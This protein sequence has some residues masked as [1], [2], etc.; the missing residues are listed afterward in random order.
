MKAVAGAARR[1]SGSHPLQYALA[2]RADRL[3]RAARQGRQDDHRAREHAAVAD[4]GRH[5]VVERAALQAAAEDRAAEQDVLQDRQTRFRRS[6]T[7][8]SRMPRTRTGICTCTSRSRTCSRWATSFR[9][10]VGR[11]LT[12]RPAAGSA[13][14]SAVFSAC[15]RWPIEDTRIVPGPRAGARSGR[16]QGSG[17]HVHHD[18]RSSDDAV[19]QR[20]GPDR[21]RCGPPDQGIRCADGQSRRVRAPRLRKPLGILIARCVTV[22]LSPSCW[23]ASRSSRR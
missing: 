7:A 11:S 6:I 15:R 22:P 9:I 4:D 5:V 17:R 18:L 2:S 10:R 19:E 20:P 16:A 3:E 14:S 23:L 1:R 12:G 13:A 21:G 8:T